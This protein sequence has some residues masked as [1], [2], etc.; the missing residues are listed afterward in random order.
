MLSLQLEGTT[1]GE[2]TF[3]PMACVLTKATHNVSIRNK[4]LFFSP[5]WPGQGIIRS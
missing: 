4:L 1:Q 2:A 3:G 5:I